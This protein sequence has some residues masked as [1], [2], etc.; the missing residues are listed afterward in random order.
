MQGKLQDD[1]TQTRDRL[2]VEFIDGLPQLRR[3]E[4]ILEVRVPSHTR[5]RVPD[6]SFH[7]DVDGIGLPQ[8]RDHGVP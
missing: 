3:Q 1:T 5:L 8:A 2:E 7:L 4:A 6:D